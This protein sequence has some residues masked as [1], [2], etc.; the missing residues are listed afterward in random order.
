MRNP[1]PRFAS[2][3]LIGTI[4]WLGFFSLVLL[5]WL[6]LYRMQSGM[7]AGEMTMRSGLFVVF[8]MWVLMTAAMMAPSFVP[9]LK[10][11]RDL[12]YTEAANGRTSVA[13]LAGYMLAWIGF[14]ALAALAQLT[15]VRFELLGMNG[16]SSDWRLTSVL[17]LAAGAYQFSP[18]K[19]ACLTKC[20]TPM[21]YF[22]SQWR[23]GFAGAARMGWQLGLSC[24]GCCWA[25]MSLGFIGGVMNLAW[26]G[27]ATALM[28]VEKL[29]DLGRVITKPLGIV[30][31][32]GGV[33]AAIKALGI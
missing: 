8:F 25:L 26:M 1:L 27:I 21:T 20:R 15:F 30:L 17:L 24:L 31:L 2:P 6:T 13:L 12:T 28:V 14:S 22:M 18:L 10:T 29:P 5:A 33:F 4:E 23:P 9:S 7:G 3:R 19:S 11:Y 16:A 32:A